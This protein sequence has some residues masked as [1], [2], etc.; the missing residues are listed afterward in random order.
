MAMTSS[1]PPQ[2]RTRAV[3]VGEHLEYALIMAPPTTPRPSPPTRPSPPKIPV[4]PAAPIVDVPTSFLVPMAPIPDTPLPAFV[5][6]LFPGVISGESVP[7]LATLGAAS[8][9]LTVGQVLPGITSG[10]AYDNDAEPFPENPKPTYPPH[11][12]RTGRE[13]DFSAEFFVDTTGRVEEK[14]ITIPDAVNREFADAVRRVLVRWRFRPAQ[15]NGLAV[16]RTVRQRFVFVLAGP[17][18]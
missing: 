11:M 5:D 17:V 6:T 8:G 13:A 7:H 16:S 1:K 10:S 9:P 12:L 4:P 3:E 14:T 2:L 15:E 18:A